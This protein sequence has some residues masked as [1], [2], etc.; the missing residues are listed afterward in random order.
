MPLKKNDST[1]IDVQIGA[2]I[3]LRR[4][5]L[6]LTQEKLAESLGVTFQ[7]VQKYERGINRLSAARLVQLSQILNVSI[8][9]FFNGMEE[10]SCLEHDVGEGAVS[11]E[12]QGLINPE[13]AEL[14]R[15]FNQIE[16]PAVR[17]QIISLIKILAKSS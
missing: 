16:D 9:F 4:A 7:Q 15:A 1:H 8:Q 2:Q 14:I 13:A 11:Y 5:L 3:R 17:R 6:G 10:V 12:A